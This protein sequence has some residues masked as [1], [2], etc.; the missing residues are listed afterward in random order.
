MRAERAC[1]LIAIACL[2]VSL[3]SAQVST[4]PAVASWRRNLD[5]TKGKGGNAAI[6]AIVG[7]I[8]ADVESARYT[9]TNVYVG[10]AGIPSHVVG[11]F[12]GNPNT[13]ADQ[14][15]SFRISRTPQAATGVHTATGLGQIG[16]LVNGV[17]IFNAKDAMS[18]N[19]QGIWNRNAMYW[20][21]QSF[22]TGLGHPTM[23][24]VYHYHQQPTLLRAQRGDNGIDHSP[25]IGF[26]FDGFPIY[27][28]YGF[29]NPDGTGGVTRI[30]TSYQ[31]RNITERTTLPDGTVLPM[32]QHGP[33]VNATYPLGA[34]VEDFEYVAG[35]GDLDEYN[36]RSGVTP[37]YPAGTF[38]YFA[39]IDANGVS[40]YP[41][42]LGPRYWGVLDTGNTGPGGGHVTVPGTATTYAPF[43]VY[44]NEFELG[45]AG[46]ISLA[47]AV[48]NSTIA[49]AYSLSGLGP[50]SFPF[51]DM[52]L[53]L[54]IFR[55]AT[56]HADATG[57]AT[58]NF[59]IGA[60][61]VG[62][63]IYI[64][65]LKLGTPRELSTA[66]RVVVLP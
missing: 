61:H 36:G 60:G 9:A 54:P 41:Y 8:D 35:L 11:P 37:E 1:Q 20:E 30:R 28:P 13:P 22:D 57:L 65:A 23:S 48:A 50:T 29:A 34:F 46:R 19:N 2:T 62:S 31:T 33:P 7:A 58:T 12:P 49:V 4:D 32:S 59:P 25:L 3:A 52:A 14:N 63:T 26:G 27:G 51:G 55:V 66:E 43:S 40:A 5:G 56:L 47:G 17:P 21:A 44:L 45:G 64:Q 53:S 24:G 39:T 10:A 42:L 18:W 15:W 6:Q 38:A 16:A